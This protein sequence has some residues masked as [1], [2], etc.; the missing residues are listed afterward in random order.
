MPNER[1]VMDGNRDGNDFIA[2][3]LTV[4]YEAIKFA[5]RV[6]KQS[7]ICRV[8]TGHG[9]YICSCYN[10]TGTPIVVLINVNK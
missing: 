10:S 7:R 1:L 8:C 3:L 6:A 4:I 9:I 2:H 5:S